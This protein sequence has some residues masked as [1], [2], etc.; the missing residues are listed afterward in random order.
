MGLIKVVVADS[1]PLYRRGVVSMLESDGIEV[2]ADVD[3][4]DAALTAV[5]ELAPDVVL[6]D[7]RLDGGCGIEATAEIVAAAPGTEVIVLSDVRDPD[8]ML[9]SIR[10][11]AA[12]FLTKDQAPERLGAA[13][14][15]VMDG[16][17]AVS[18]RMARYLAQDVREGDRRAQLAARLPHRERL[19]PRQLEVLRLI[20]AGRSTSQIAGELYL[21]PETVRWHVKAIL[22]K[23]RAGSRAEAAAALGEAFV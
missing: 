15:G 14:R 9:R 13:V 5:R 16:E 21:S 6:V 19:T 2:V 7:L 3:R 22:R 12:G 8:E 17:I 20:A 10:A 18:R 11:G 1:Q 4:I 23:L